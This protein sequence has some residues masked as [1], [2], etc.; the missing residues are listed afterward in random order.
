MDHDGRCHG[1][2]DGHDLLIGTLH[3]HVCAERV[4]CGDELFLVDTVPGVESGQ[5]LKIGPGRFGL[6]LVGGEIIDAQLAGFPHRVEHGFMCL[7]CHTKSPGGEVGA[8]KNS[9]Q[10]SEGR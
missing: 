7:F 4:G 3:L 1:R 6:D 9:G 8:L 10:F 2:A 5:I